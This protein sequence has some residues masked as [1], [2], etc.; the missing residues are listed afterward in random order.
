[1]IGDRKTEN[2]FT[3]IKNGVETIQSSKSTQPI[4]GKSFVTYV[5]KSN[6]LYD[7]SLSVPQSYKI[8]LVEFTYEPSAATKHH[9]VKP[10]IFY[11]LDAPDVMAAPIIE[12]YTTNTGIDF[13]QL[14]TGQGFASW[15][16]QI[17]NIDAATHT[18]YFKFFF[19]GTVKGTFVTSAL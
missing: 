13:F 15:V 9:I 11:R 17:T 3:N 6:D 1:M 16:I 12:S 10:T 8:A 5:T 14:R 18:F 4:S 2:I 19:Y 7:F